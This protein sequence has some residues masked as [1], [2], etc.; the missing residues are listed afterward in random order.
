MAFRAMVYSYPETLLETAERCNLYIHTDLIKILSSLLNGAM[1][2]GSV[3]RNLQNLCYFGVRFE[4]RK[5]D[6]KIKPTQ[7]MKHTN[8]ILTYFEYF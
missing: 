5:V 4:R 8:S 1:L 7:K 2:T 3:T 6:K